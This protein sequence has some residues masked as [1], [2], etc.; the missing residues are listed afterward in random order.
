MVVS[1]SVT[2]RKWPIFLY[3][4]WQKITAG[5]TRRGINVISVQAERI[6][7]K[8]IRPRSSDKTFNFGE[9]DSSSPSILSGC[10][11]PEKNPW[12]L[13][14]KAVLSIKHSDYD[15]LK[16][17]L[18][19]IKIRWTP[20]SPKQIYS[21]HECYGWLV[22]LVCAYSGTPLIWDFDKT[23]LFF[24]VSYYYTVRKYSS[25]TFRGARIWL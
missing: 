8:R 19:T 13:Q 6:K 17:W 7:R 16:I 23:F 12:I 15:R 10:L 5:L 25:W 3:W 21:G 2:R 11:N 24:Y 14:R 20:V 22:S 18:P 9:W 1:F 4:S